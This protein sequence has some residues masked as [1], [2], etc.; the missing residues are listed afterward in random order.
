MFEVARQNRYRRLIF[1]FIAKAQ[2]IGM[3]T[4]PRRSIPLSRP[5]H[6]PEAADYVADALAS[7]SLG[8]GGKYGSWCETYIENMTGCVRALMTNS[9]S[10]ALD[11]ACLLA[12]LA[13]GDEVIVPSFA[14]PS[15]ASAVV[16]CGA[17]PVFVDIEPQYLTI[18]RA[19]VDTALSP[20]TKAIITV[21]YG[22]MPCDYEGLSQLA[23]LNGLTIIEDAAHA[24]DAW[25][26]RKA[27]GTYG[28]VGIYSFQQTKNLSCGEG[29]ALLVNDAAL[30]AR[31]EQICDKG[32]NRGD[33]VRGQIPFYQWVEAG[34]GIG[35]NEVSAAV[36][37]AQLEQ[38]SAIRNSHRDLFSRYMER[39]SPLDETGK[40][41]LIRPAAS[42]DHNA[43]VVAFLTQDAA[44]RSA[45]LSALN[46]QGIG[47]AFHYIPLHSSRAGRKFG[48]C[49]DGCPVAEDAAARIVRLPNYM[50]LSEDEI[51]FICAEV[52]TAVAAG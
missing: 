29:G 21:D 32:T 36:L 41:K 44:S 2:T 22:G 10:S 34:A 17:T 28:A 19:A 12:R 35:M 42:H 23:E 18:D 47:A 50:G 45:I 26:G 3:Q 33:M 9:A 1:G 37:R 8:A 11:A 31:A 24:F 20:R 4:E 27:L 52:V 6:T 13:P 25:L 16:R 43:H 5:I 7:R 48:L 38:S 46:N 15:A 39:L 14:F 30:V 40:I 51:D 49:P